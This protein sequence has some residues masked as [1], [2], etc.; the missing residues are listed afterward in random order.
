MSEQGRFYVAL[1]ARGGRSR[2]PTKE[3]KYH[4]ALVTGPSVETPD[5]RGMRHHITHSVQMVDDTPEMMW[6]YSEQDIPTGWTSKLLVRIYVGEVKS[7]TQV[8]STLQNTPLQPDAA[9]WN[10]FQWVKDAFMAV[11]KDGEALGEAVTDWQAVRD[12][13]MEYV[14]GK[15]KAG[16]FE[17]CR[18]FEH[19]DV[20]TWDMLGNKELAT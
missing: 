6:K 4:W 7:M 20:P 13:A 18:D 17:L 3:D 1:Y 15:I 9:G 2:M 14:E 12:K 16:R 10:C 19:D 11:A 5:T 8:H